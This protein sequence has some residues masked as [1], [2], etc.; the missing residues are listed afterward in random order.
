L[1]GTG[2]LAAAGAVASGVAGASAANAADAE[3]F[4][5]IQPSVGRIVHDPDLCCGCRVCEIVCTLSHWGFVNPDYSN[6]RIRTDILGG[7]ISEAE[8]CKQCDGPECVAACP[9]GAMAKRSDGVVLSDPDTC[10]G[11]GSCVA[12]CPY[13]APVLDEAAGI[14]NKCDL[15][16]DRVE[17]GQEPLCVC[18][19]PADARLFGELTDEDGE[20][21]QAIAASGAEVLQAEL[22]CAPSVYYC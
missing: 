9:T 7:Y 6:I 12:A 13:G 10:I 11:C 8:T 4:A 14:V 5:N 15:C 17:A 18:S 20:L 21:A 16:I 2:A 3:M 1:A 19:C 22:G